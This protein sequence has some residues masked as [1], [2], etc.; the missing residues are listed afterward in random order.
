MKTENCLFCKI[1]NNLEPS[2]TVWEDH[3]FVAFLDIAPIKF[4]HILLIPKKHSKNVFDLSAADY[5][6]IFK[7]SKR[8]S[9][10]LRLATSA[11]T[12]GLA[13]EGLSVPHTHIHLVPINKSNELNPERAKKATES[14][15]QEMQK[16]LLTFF[17]G[18]S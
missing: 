12:V 1:A 14:E 15:L 18:L 8:L 5:S 10:R 11:K 9:R 17:E 7:I 3:D 4:G 6:K 16:N 2:Y 13:I